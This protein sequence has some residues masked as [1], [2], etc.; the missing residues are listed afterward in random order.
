[1]GI[2]ANFKGKVYRKEQSKQQLKQPERRFTAMIR[3]LVP[4]PRFFFFVDT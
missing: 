4:S 3:N 1:M 2:F